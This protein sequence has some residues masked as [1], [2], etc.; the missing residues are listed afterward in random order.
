MLSVYVPVPNLSLDKKAVKVKQAIRIW[1]HLFAF[2]GMWINSPLLAIR[3]AQ[4]CRYGS[5]ARVGWSSLNSRKNHL[6]TT[7]LSHI[8]LPRGG[9]TISSVNRT[10]STLAVDRTQRMKHRVF[11]AVGSNLGNRFQ[12]I[13]SAISLLCDP[14]FD[15]ESSPTRLVKTSFLH[16]TAPMY[17]TDQ[18]AFLNGALEI[19]TDL[20]PHVL[21]RRLKKVELE[22]GRNFSTVRN[23]PRPV[24]LDILFYD[25]LGEDGLV[26][27]P[28]TIDTPDLEIPHPR[29]AEREFVLA[30]LC[31]VAGRSHSHPILNTTVGDL[32][33]KLM[34][35]TGDS[36]AVRVLPLPRDRTIVFNETVIMG[37]LNVTPDSFSDGGK[38]NDSVDRAVKRAMEMESEGARIIDIGGESTRPGAKET[39]IEEQI[40]RT[41]PVIERIR[42]VSDVPISIDTRHAAVARAAIKAGADIV[43]DISGGDFDPQMLSTVAELGVPVILMHMR[44][45]PESMQKMTEYDDVVQEV[46]DSLLERSRNAENAGI[47]RWMQVLDPGIG[48]A[49]TL[50]GN[51]LLLKSLSTIRSA[52]GDMPILLGTSRKGFIGKITGESIAEERDYG[53]AASCVAALCLGS[54]HGGCNI[55]RVHNVKGMKQA[56]MLMD[57]IRKAR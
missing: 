33:S 30:P 36:E 11:L 4:A 55:I 13:A 57:A 54:S 8:F 26:E 29:I 38:W 37:I 40:Q 3:S 15:D 21:L 18:P 32:F 10:F 6:S 52:L 45:T 9:A 41:V 51:L 49:K 22:M 35:K 25:G 19:E 28:M 2:L 42:Q 46:V 27:F 16:E 20:D 5:K 39:P 47:P 48:F 24:D 31:E 56:S 17:I 34:D 50:N 23:G 53:S 7:P 1:F 43:N 12:N 14:S 44:G